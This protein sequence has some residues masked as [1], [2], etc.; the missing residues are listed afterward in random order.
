MKKKREM[1]RLTLILSPA[2]R[3]SLETLLLRSFFALVGDRLNL[4]KM[5][6]E[7]RGGGRG[8]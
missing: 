3:S 2:N 5:S 1:D 4:R 6:L 7:S 8:T